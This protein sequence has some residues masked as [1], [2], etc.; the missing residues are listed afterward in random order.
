MIHILGNTFLLD[1]SPVRMDSVRCKH[2]ASAKIRKIAPMDRFIRKADNF[3]F[4]HVSFE[5]RIITNSSK[6]KCHLSK[7][8][9]SSTSYN[10][11]WYSYFDGISTEIDERICKKNKGHSR[12]RSFGENLNFRNIY[13]KLE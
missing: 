3:F 1:I 8:N 10:C 5:N 11:C 6:S 4:I 12:R 7:V 2:I 13:R 9:E